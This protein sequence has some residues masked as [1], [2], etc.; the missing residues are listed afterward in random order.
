MSE[1]FGTVKIKVVV[2]WIFLPQNYI[3]RHNP[4]TTI[5][6]EELVAYIDNGN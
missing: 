3:H 5:P 6:A 2:F 4:K 1:V